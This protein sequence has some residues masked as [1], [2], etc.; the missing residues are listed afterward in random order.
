MGDDDK[1]GLLLQED[2]RSAGPDISG[3]PEHAGPDSTEPRKFPTPVPGDY[4]VLEPRRLGRW[5]RLLKIALPLALLVSVVV[6]TTINGPFKIFSL[7]EISSAA[8]RTVAKK[9]QPPPTASNEQLPVGPVPELVPVP[10]ALS[11][12]SFSVFALEPG[13]EPVLF[14]NG[15][16][17]WKPNV[18]D[19]VFRIV[20]KASYSWSHLV[21]EL[22]GTVPEDAP[23]LGALTLKA[24]T[25][26]GFQHKYTRLVAGTSGTRIDLDGELADRISLTVSQN[27]GF[28][29]ISRIVPYVFVK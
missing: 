11:V 23:G 25:G 29:G 3:F 20:T 13:S 22:C 14:N 18:A 28:A 19:S 26:D 1:S 5:G 15:D 27:G 16:A 10:M 12:D 2:S 24:E 9:I 17:C 8:R 7:H 21:V 6:F 4:R